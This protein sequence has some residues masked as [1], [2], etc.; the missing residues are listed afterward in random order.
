M[1]TRGGMVCRVHVQLYCTD[2]DAYIYIY[3][4]IYNIIIYIYIM[5]TLAFMC[6][7]RGS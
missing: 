4:F 5:Y 2:V 3:I 7:L 1:G 6:V